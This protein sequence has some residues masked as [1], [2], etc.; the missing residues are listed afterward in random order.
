MRR[1][2]PAKILVLGYLFYSLIGFLCLSLPI[3]HKE[4]VSLIDSYFTAVS[5]LSTTGLATIDIGNEYNFL[6]QLIILLLIQLGGIGYMTFSSFVVLCT[7]QK[8]SSYRQKIGKSSF[9]VPQ[10]FSIQEFIISVVVFSF[11]AELI[12]AIA[13]SLV[14]WYK[15]IDYWLWQ[16]IFHSISAFC[17]AGLSL[18]SEGFIPFQ[19][20]IACNVIISTLAILGSL[21]FIVSLDFYKKW[22]KRGHFLSFTT[23][24]ILIMTC[25]FLT[26]GTILFFILESISDHATAFDKLLI[27]FFQV[28]SATT[29][30]G[31]NTIDIGTLSPPM[32]ILLGFLST[33]GA[34][35]SGTGGGQKN[36]SFATLV[37][38]VK[39]TL[40]DH[41]TTFWRHL[42]PVNRIKIATVSFIF[43]VF[44]LSLSLF[45][46]SLSEHHHQ[47]TISLFF[48]AANALNNSGL[49]MGVTSDLT[50]LGKIFIALLMLMGRV[51][52]LTFGVAISSQTE[53]KIF[54]YKKTELIT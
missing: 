3:C 44:T 26:L 31:F 21:G 8:L 32:I 13:L 35:P 41:P 5:S 54:T 38:F 49:S 16:G 51:G 30:T 39:N 29:T 15:N 14:F 42:I 2:H 6:G 23:K 4:S 25:S 7:S 18:F 19:R 48:E 52:V 46:L 47:T 37:A 36:T 43:Y 11:L 33:F 10:H 34:S 40:K 20:N 22:T 24:V 12:G 17:T 50:D 1:L 28:T 53:E 27:G 45:V 9:P